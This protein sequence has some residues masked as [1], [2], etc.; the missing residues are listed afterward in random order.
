MNRDI[1][2]GGEIEDAVMELQTA[3]RGKA[4]SYEIFVSVDKGLIVDTK[5]GEIDS[6]K[7]RSNLGLGLRTIKNG[8]PGFGFTSVL[9][10]DAI[11]ALATD[12]ITGSLSVEPDK[13]YAFAHPMRRKADPD[14]PDLLSTLVDP[15]YGRLKEEEKIEISRRI[16]RSARSADKRIVKA[17]KSSY[18]ETCA[19]SRV[20]NSEGVDS[21]HQATFFSGSI[22]VVAAEGD[23]NQ[24]G[25]DVGMGHLSTDVDPEAIGKEAA[26]VAAGLLG[27]KNIPSTKSPVVL[28]N[29]IVI[30]LLGA[31]SGS[32]SGESVLKG[33]SMLADKIGK[34]VLS[35][36]ITI[37]DD[38]LIP[39]GWGSADVDGEGV[40]KRSTTLVEAG[41]LKSFIYDT[42][43][44]KKA[45]VASTG[46]SRRGGFKS[47]PS[48]GISNYYLK[49]GKGSMEELVAEMHDGLLI[50]DLMGV[51][52]INP[53]TG[54]FSLGAQGFV[55]K[56]GKIDHPV[57]GIAIAGELLD[58]FSKVERVGSDMRYL[59]SIGAPSLL[60]KEL[61]IS[62]S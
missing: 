8:R 39:G 42:Y 23:E 52:T 46:N 3:L 44:G 6:F 33:R 26:R 48:I 56:D 18:S 28:E 32:F 21:I 34:T 20:I 40:L 53:V 29:G 54:E 11:T 61:D 36:D 47:P 38:G 25:W 30:E 49:A 27:G 19:A 55:V 62:G 9:N 24:M 17:R 2:K 58:L 35:K 41:E 43:W 4:D 22:A 7:V 12:T 16:E 50:T 15:D 10:K 57:R 37:I 59:G 5:E 31:L 51:H 1:L 14:A 13:A 45:G 60:L